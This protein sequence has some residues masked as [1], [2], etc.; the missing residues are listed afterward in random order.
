LRPRKKNRSK[1]VRRL[2]HQGIKSSQIALIGPAAHAKG[3]L[4]NH[5]DVD[6]VPLIDDAT[7]WRRGAGV[8]VTSARAFKG[9][10][11]D[12]VIGYGLSGFGALFT[13]TDLYVAWTRARHRLFLICQ[14]GEVRA[15]AEAAQADAERAVS[16]EQSSVELGP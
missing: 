2:L 4:A 8:L 5:R 13:Q 10:E 16:V 11:A 9:L 7:D 15:A 12:V 3:S 6:G 1:E 14:G